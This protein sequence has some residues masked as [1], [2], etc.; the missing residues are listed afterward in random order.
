[1][2]KEL[3]ISLVEDA[4]M[5]LRQLNDMMDDNCGM[6]PP[7]MTDDEESEVQNLFTLMEELQEHYC[8]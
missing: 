3:F 1:M 6:L 5:A 4:S 8:E 2:D 7:A